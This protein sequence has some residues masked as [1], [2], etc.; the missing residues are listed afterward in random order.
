MF[1]SFYP[2]ITAYRVQPVLSSVSPSPCFYC[3]TTSQFSQNQNPS[4]FLVPY[5]HTCGTIPSLRNLTKNVVVL[6][7]SLSLSH[8]SLTALHTLQFITLSEIPPLNHM[9]PIHFCQ[10]WLKVLNIH[11]TFPPKGMGHG[12]MA[13]LEDTWESTGRLNLKGRKFCCRRAYTA[14]GELLCI[15]P[16]SDSIVTMS[17]DQ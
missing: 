16:R 12:E 5:F 7:Y 10:V 3:C 13:E 15:L 9:D 4:H 8:L 17:S 2:A 11:F 14:R 6:A 1:R